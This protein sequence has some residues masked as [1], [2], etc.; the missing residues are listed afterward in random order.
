MK[1]CKISRAI[2]AALLACGV[3]A[4]QAPVR[5]GI[6]GPPVCATPAGKASTAVAS[7]AARPNADSALA[8]EKAS[9]GQPG[10]LVGTPPLENFDIARD[11]IADY[12]DCVGSGGCYWRDLDAT[13]QRAEAALK[14]QI[15]MI[16]PGKKA[17]LL[18][19]IDETTLS[20]YC[21][22]RREDFGYIDAM[23]NAWVVTPQADVAIPGTLRLFKEA[24]AA[25]VTVFFVTGRPE[26]QRAATERNLRAAGFIGWE[27]VVMRSQS[28]LHI[29]TL[30]YKPLARKK[31]A[32]Q[33]Y[34][35]LMSVGDQCE[36]PE[37]RLRERELSVKLPNPFGFFL[38]A[39]LSSQLLALAKGKA[40]GLPQAGKS[41]QAN[42]L[43]A[44]PNGKELSKSGLGRG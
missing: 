21:E 4:A 8:V 25:G 35:L 26:S 17:A 11:R 27:R 20:S 7:V 16:R 39:P 1:P 5:A 34:R 23:F 43:A 42:G 15:A 38:N 33:G 6:D 19:D 12:A 18:L 14:T 36:R 30:E 3:A 31:I 2:S 24:R 37:R 28:E 29:P 13:E 44:S 10:V 22:W 9:A 40:K 32:A 41:L